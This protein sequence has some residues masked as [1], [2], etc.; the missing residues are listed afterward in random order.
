MVVKKLLGLLENE[1]KNISEYTIIDTSCGYGSFFDYD[2]LIP[3]K[4]YIGGDIDGA[5]IKIAQERHPNI[6]F[7]KINALH[8]IQRSKYHIES[9]EKIII[10]GNPPYN[11]VTSKVKK[12]IKQGFVCEIDNDIRTRDLGISF[13]L[14]YTK[15]RPEYV[16][17]LH[18]LSYL[19]K[20]A[21]YEL[22]KPFLYQYKLIDSLIM[23]SQAFKETS[24]G[25]GFPIILSLYKNDNKGTMYSSIMN[26]NF[27]TVD[28]K[29]FN[30]SYDT[31]SNYLNKYPQKY[32][33]YNGDAPLFWTMRD[34]NAL[35]RSKT[36][37][38]V[39]SYNT[40]IVKNEIIEY[41]CYVDVF[42]DYIKHIPYY[43]G[44][45]DIIID[46]EEFVKIK[47]AFIARSLQKHPFIKK[48]LG[49]RDYILNNHSIE[50][51]FKKLL[52][53]SYVH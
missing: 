21:N 29:L 7:Y 37:V 44:N 18:P 53:E 11:D 1:Q 49:D 39:Y 28:G 24:K 13:M 27:K 23:N 35:K 22:L 50:K 26:M 48:Y 5:A 8:N 17:I 52:G 32:V 4:R 9:N 36:F 19:I 20:K 10:V 16:C 38:Q 14:G 30:I 45:C 47:D 51:Y 42:K 3:P 12:S 31:I 40:V 43:L 46:N 33:K 2:F 25:T 15:L 6:S 34:I 41:Y